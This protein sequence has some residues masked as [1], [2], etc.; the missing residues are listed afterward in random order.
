MLKKYLDFLYRVF[1]GIGGDGN[2][3][4]FS[5]Y[6]TS[7]VMGFAFIGLIALIL[8]GLY[9]AFR[10]PMFGWKKVSA[11]SKNE[12]NTALKEFKDYIGSK[13]YLESHGLDDAHK[14]E[15]FQKWKHI[16]HRIAVYKF[17]YIVGTIVIYVPFV[18][19]TL[20]YLVY[21]LFHI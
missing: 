21:S 8:L 2:S 12:C 15:L 16:D 13:D 7:I 14:D 20:L 19:P 3:I 18:V 11:K 5:D 4:T 1:Q 17:W 6:L 9:G 10:L